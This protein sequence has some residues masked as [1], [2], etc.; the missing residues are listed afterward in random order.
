[1]LFWLKLTARPA[2]VKSIKKEN[3]MK[4]LLLVVFSVGLLTLA[5]C[6]YHS[7]QPVDDRYYKKSQSVAWPGDEAKPTQPVSAEE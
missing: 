1:M 4:K 5:A 2:F 6:S 7:K 3:D